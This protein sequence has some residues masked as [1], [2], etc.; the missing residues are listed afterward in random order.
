[1]EDEALARLHYLVN[2]RRELGLVMG[3]HAAGKS[4]LLQVFRRELVRSGAAIAL[5]GLKD[6]DGRQFLWR[7]AA[8]LG[9]QPAW[10][11]NS[12]RLWRRLGDWFLTQQMLGRRAVVLLDDSDLAT[13]QVQAHVVRLALGDG[14]PDWPLTLVLAAHTRGLPRLGTHLIALAALRIDLVCYRRGS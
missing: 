13:R 4:T 1:M 5:L 6:I 7:L 14:C 11:D 12:R 2:Q 3:E 8:G 9:V 10:G